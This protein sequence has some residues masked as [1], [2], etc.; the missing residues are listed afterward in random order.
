MTTLHLLPDSARTTARSINNSSATLAAHLQELNSA[1]RRLDP[2]WQGG[3]K[4]TFSSEM[5]SLLRLLNGRQEELALLAARLERE[6]A[7]WEE[8][9]QRGA[10]GWQSGQWTAAWL[11]SQLP[12]AAGGS[13][14]GG[15]GLAAILP[16]MTAVSIGSFFA[17]IP[18]WLKGILDQLFPPA[19]ILSPIPE[20]PPAPQ[21][22][23]LHRLIN[24]KLPSQPAP[25]ESPAPAA[26]ASAQPVETVPAI[27]PESKFDILHDVPAQS[28]GSLYG[29]AACAPTS[30][31]MV[32]D[33]FH[34]KDSNNQTIAT[35][36]LISMMDKGDGTPGQGVSLSNL[37]DELSDLGYH[38][39][40]TQ[41]NASLDDLKSQLQ[42]GPVI[43]TA[44]VK[45]V[46]PGS[47]TSD[48]PRAVTGPGSVMHAMV[49]KGV[50]SDGVLVNDPWSGSEMQI[51]TDTFNQMWSNGSNGLYAIRP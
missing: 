4:D 40:T 9:D 5:D 39:I 10:S 35:D 11:R 13:G 43:V 34:G 22:G 12:S 7:E 6:I 1:A 17:G 36:K 37:N 41:V 33:Y 21:P 29:S 48:V 47:V 49:V 51:P 24:E 27:Q 20:G 15:P 28:Q 19:P 3:G 8:T 26:S 2:A 31:S 38:N 42:S 18:A 23:A 14:F 16:L 30:A 32:L 46:G 25:P 45:I 44:G 50:G